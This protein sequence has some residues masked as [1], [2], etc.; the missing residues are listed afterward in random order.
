[1]LTPNQ[2]RARLI[3]QG[4]TLAE[5]GRR[6]GVK[7]VTVSVIVGKHGKSKRIQAAIAKAIGM[8]YREVWGENNHRRAA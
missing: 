4:I 7:R 8:A 5:L 2:I 6:I 1:M 3:E